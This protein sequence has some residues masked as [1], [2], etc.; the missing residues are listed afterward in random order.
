MTNIEDVM[1][2]IEDVMT[3]IEDVMT[4]LNYFYD[5]MNNLDYFYVMT[6]LKDLLEHLPALLEGEVGEKVLDE[7]RETHHQVVEDIG[8]HVDTGHDL[9]VYQGLLQLVGLLVA[10]LY[11]ELLDLCQLA[12][13]E[14]VG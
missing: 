5:V 13:K 7:V 3:S 1:T 4:N 8:A 12:W 9:L 11:R 14:G 2:N 10:F 6:N